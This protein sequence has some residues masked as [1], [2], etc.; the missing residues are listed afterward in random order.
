[1]GYGFFPLIGT[2]VFWI[3]LVASIVLLVIYKRIYP[4][5]YILF[6]GLYIFTVGF[7]IDVFELGK[8]AIILL[9]FFSALVFIALGYYF[10]K[11]S[12]GSK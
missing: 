2:G 4:V 9:L 10:S 11:F 7:A 12:H 8:N 6:A 1:M 3:G 5:V